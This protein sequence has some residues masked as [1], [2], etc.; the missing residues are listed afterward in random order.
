M[1]PAIL[2]V[3]DETEPRSVLREAL[4]RRFGNDYRVEAFDSA[5]RALDEMNAMRERGEPLALVIAD[6][7][8]P[9]M[10]GLELLTEVH[11]R[12]PAARRALLVSWNDRSASASILAG[13][14]F[15]QLDNYLVKPW[16]PAEVHL[17]PAVTEFLSEWVRATGPRLE[18]VRVVSTGLSPRIHEVRELLDRNG[19]PYGCYTDDSEQGRRLLEGAGL[20]ICPAPLVLLLEDHVL[21]NPSNEEIADVLGASNLEERN[22]D[23]AIIGAGPA[24][25]A[26][27]VYAAS[28]GLRT[29][30]VERQAIG[31]QAG[32]SSLIRNYLGFPRGISGADLAQR[33]YRQAWLFGAK[34]VFAR[35]VTSLAA[36]GGKCVMSLSGNVEITARA[37]VVATG[38][39]Y[40]RLGVE[41]VERFYG[42]GVFYATPSDSRLV[43]GME[44]YV[45]GGGNAAGQAVTHLAR[46][47]ER[48]T[49]VVRADS[50]AR[51][52]SDYLVRSIRRLPNVEI[53]VESE[54]VGGDGDSALRHVEI[55]NNVTGTVTRRRADALFVMIG[56]DPRTDWLDGT[57]QRDPSGFIPTGGDVDC[58]A[59]RWTLSRAPL[60]FETSLP[61]VFAAGDVR[62]GSVKRVASAVGE[63]AMAIQYVHQYLAGLRTGSV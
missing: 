50:P 37:V 35:S 49:L 48:V 55:R 32:A 5:R 3:D 56:A 6:Q 52:M 59:A 29:I 24:G 33:A 21:V 15:D 47:A 12:H 51:G 44:V 18:M 26:A 16:I 41:S 36:S 53:M 34:Y 14:A 63:G 22:C 62:L 13:S 7:W 2:V 31:G 43:K 25:L 20:A 60:P 1:Q 19:I 58:Q 10:T 9:E 61:G 39:S 4:V 28:E 8:M 30:V 11:E 23:L 17:Y 40:R 54:V 42:T 38:A 45:A 57:V 46:N 27:A